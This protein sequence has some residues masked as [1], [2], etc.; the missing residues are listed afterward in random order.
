MFSKGNKFL[1]C[2]WRFFRGGRLG[3]A[4]RPA[5]SARSLPLDHV[6]CCAGVTPGLFPVLDQPFRPKNEF[7]I[8]AGGGFSRSPYDQF[9]FF[10]WMTNSELEFEGMMSRRKNRRRGG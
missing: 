10:L 3:L 8:S 7:A 2:S 6:E 5:N 9:A 1:G 4:A